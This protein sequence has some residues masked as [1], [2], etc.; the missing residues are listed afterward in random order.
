MKNVLSP[1][2]V[3][4]S[5]TLVAQQTDWVSFSKTETITTIAQEGN[6]IWVG[7][8]TGA[9]KIDK[10]SGAKKYFDLTNSPLPDSYVYKIAIDKNGVKWF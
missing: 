1:I 8:A 9:V 6:Y 7:S 3:L 2:L 10:N 4:F 5:L